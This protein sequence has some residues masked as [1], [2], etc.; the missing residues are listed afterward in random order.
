MS[1]K[2]KSVGR[3]VMSIIGDG[4]PKYKYSSNS[5]GNDQERTAD[6]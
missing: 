6:F 5:F 1:N 3:G 4:K 2:D